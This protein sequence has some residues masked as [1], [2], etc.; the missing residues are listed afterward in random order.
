MDIA[1]HVPHGS[2]R[3][4]VMGERGARNEEPTSQ[5]LEAMAAIVKEGVESGVLGFSSSRTM[6]HR[7]IDGEPVPGTIAGAE[8]MVALGA[9]V[10]QAGG[11]FVEVSSDIG[12][13]GLEGNFKGDIDWMR[14]LATDHGLTVTYVLTQDDRKP[15]Q[16]RDLLDISS[17]PIDGEGRVVAQVAG[18]PAGLLFGLETSLH[19]FKMHPTYMK[20]AEELSHADLVVELAKPEVKA[21]ILSETTEFTGRFNEG[22]AHAM[23][24]MYP[25]GDEPGYEP[26]PS[27]SIAALAE[28]EGRG[29]YEMVYEVLLSRDGRG[30]VFYPLTD[31]AEHNLNPTYERLGHHGAFLSL[32]DGGAHCRL[33]CD[34]SNP[35]YI[36][37]HWTRDRVKGP[38]LT[39]EAAIKLLARDSAEV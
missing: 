37:S 21:K 29:P 23:D 14:T 25:L 5:D 11:G 35:T 31:Y 34:S 19:P 17:A 16:W 18:R 32:S 33:I 2:V 13:G 6:L 9:A 4:Y 38:K 30:L 26:D 8:E 36:L 7:A 10:A 22:V 12:L 39:V 3:A 28:S 1:T 27:D 20:L 15:D 24:K